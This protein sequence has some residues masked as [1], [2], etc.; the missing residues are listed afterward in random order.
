MARRCPV[1]PGVFFAAQRPTPRMHVG[2]LS[3]AG[4]VPALMP[5]LLLL[6]L[7]L[8]CLPDRWEA[9]TWMDSAGMSA[10]FTW[11]GIAGLIGLAGLLSC[12]IRVGLSQWPDRRETLLL[13]YHSWRF[14]HQIG[15]FLVYI[16]G[17]YIFRWGWAV[18]SMTSSEGRLPPGAELFVLAPLLAGLIFSWCCFYGADRAF[19]EIPPPPDLDRTFGENLA[20]AELARAPFWSRQSHLAFHLRHNLA[21]VCVPILLI[22]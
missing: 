12:R 3:R 16:V 20:E 14:Y 4:G 9:W 11:L 13:R 6:L 19:H 10:S 15:L 22:V 18:Q 1:L 7:T 2:A 21:L 8:A 17:L 5:L